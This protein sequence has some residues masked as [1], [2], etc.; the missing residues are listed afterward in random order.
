MVKT[1]QHFTGD[2]ITDLTS[3]LGLTPATSGGSGVTS[4]AS[5]VP[6]SWRWGEVMVLEGAQVMLCAHIKLSV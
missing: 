5:I 6:E 1:L 3:P 4:S 2:M